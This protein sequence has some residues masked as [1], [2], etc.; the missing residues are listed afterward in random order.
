MAP[1]LEAIES[2]VNR[3]NESQQK[4]ESAFRDGWESLERGVN[5]GVVNITDLL[6][7]RI[8]SFEAK[9]VDSQKLIQ[10]Q[11]DSSHSLSELTGLIILM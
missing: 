7:S 1:R 3:T 5:G 9:M 6:D 2:A 10:D 8:T 11:V 4:L